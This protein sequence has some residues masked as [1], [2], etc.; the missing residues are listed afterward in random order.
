MS[1]KAASV[2]GKK[3]GILDYINKMKWIYVGGYPENTDVDV[4][5]LSS[6][7]AAQ[8][9]IRNFPYFLAE[10]FSKDIEVA[11]A[12]ENI[13]S[14]KDRNT[15][16]IKILDLS[17]NISEKI[18]FGLERRVKSGNHPGFPAPYGYTYKNNRLIVEKKEFW[19]V[20][21]IFSLYINGKS[22]SEIADILN[23]GKVPTKKGKNWKKQTIAKILSN[24]IYCGYL[25]WSNILVK[26]SH[27]AII[28]EKEYE[29]ALSRLKGLSYTPIVNDAF[30][31]QSRYLKD[32]VP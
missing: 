3:K 9:E 22:L 10:L 16:L 25:R 4:V 2:S 15:F 21:K 14:F 20:K 26:G 5:V 13:T 6:L 27:K 31:F 30:D 19:H 18:R 8:R 11:L 24:P 32:N 12:R 7:A 17:Q 29:E 23:K 28:S 1:I